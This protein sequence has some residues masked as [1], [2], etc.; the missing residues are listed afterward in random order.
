MSVAEAAPDVLVLRQKVHGMGVD[1]YAAALRD[2]LPA[3]NVVVARTP[4][5]ERSLLRQT[6]IATGFDID[7]ELLEDSPLRYFACVFAGTGHLPMD[8]LAAHNV[9]VTN[10]AGVHGPNIGEQVL[11]YL[12]TFAR[13][14]HVGWR[15]GRRREWRSYQTHELNGSTVTV[16]GMGALGEAIVERLAPFGVHTV[17]IRHSP[18]KGGPTDEVFGYGDD[19][20]EPVSRSDYLVLAAPLT[21]TT[22]GLVDAELFRTMPPE[23]VLVN[24]GRGGLVE[25]DAL[26]DALRSHA[27][28]GA[29]LDVTDPEPLPEDHPLWTLENALITPHNAGHTPEYWER[30][31]DIVATNVDRVLDDG[32]SQGLR[33]QVR[34]PE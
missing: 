10:A 31:A 8:A 23:A 12:L 30:M 7:A 22:R 27:I 15:R 2:R 11:G 5:E 17:G 9:A 1:E 25:T 26:V 29:A 3:R 13:R 19:I 34:P 28:R 6:P 32:A 21:E 16:V 33:N 18:G 14:L 4:S 20:H 24:V